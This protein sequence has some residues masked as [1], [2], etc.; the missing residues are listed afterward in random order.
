MQRPPLVLILVA[1]A[2]ATLSAA[3]GPREISGP[4]V[5]RR[6]DWRN[7]SLVTTALVQPAADGRPADDVAV[8]SDEFGVR[9][10]D[11]TLLTAA[12]YE[13]KPADVAHDATRIVHRRH[14]GRAYPPG[15]PESVAVRHASRPLVAGGPKML[16]RSLVLV[17]PAGEPAPVAVEVERFSTAAPAARGWP[18]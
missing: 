6:L 5:G 9:L 14:G 17:L 3:D 11:G 7:G 4:G 16:V 18:R 10:A 8:A 1:A 2:S 12:D 15:A 13:V